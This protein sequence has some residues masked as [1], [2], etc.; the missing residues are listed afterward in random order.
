M[1]RSRR[2]IWGI[3]GTGYGYGGSGY[4]YWGL[5]SIHTINKYTDKTLRFTEA[6]SI[7]K[8]PSVSKRKPIGFTQPYFR[9][10][11]NLKPK[12][13]KGLFRTMVFKTYLQLSIPISIQNVTEFGETE[14]KLLVA[15]TSIWKTLA[16]IDQHTVILS[17]YPKIEDTL[18]SLR[19]VDFPS[20][21]PPPKKRHSTIDILKCYKWD[22]LQQI[23]RYASV[24]G[25]IR[26]SHYC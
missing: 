18:R 1:G 25:T 16:S 2:G 3:V 6:S 15:L 10:R 20:A 13:K 12:K 14:D 22:G 21:P 9:P 23:Q 17:W 11:S 5:W 24:W 8:E 26:L 19:A 7:L 4:S